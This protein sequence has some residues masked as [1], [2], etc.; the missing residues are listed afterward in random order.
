VKLADWHAILATEPATPN[1]VGTVIGEWQRLGLG[2]PDDR[3]ERLK[4]TA[5]LLGLAKIGSTT[6]LVMGDA[7]RLI[8]MLRDCEDRASLGALLDGP[9]P[10]ASPRPSALAAC[11][12]LIA[13]GW[14]SMKR[15][16]DPAAVASDHEHGGS[17]AGV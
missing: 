5:R 15:L 7:G 14:W 1:Q 16:R 12:P 11:L 17:G 2:H 4:L 13:E 10:A 6:D 9:E 8:G 3:A